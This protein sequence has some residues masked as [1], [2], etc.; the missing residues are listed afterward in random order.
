[1]NT[2][3]K[4]AF[5]EYSQF[6]E[7]GIIEKIFE[8][9]GTESKL[10]V[11]FGAWDGFHLSNTANL[12][13]NGW[14]G[15]LI[16]GNKKRFNSL[17]KKVENYNCICINA[18]VERNGKNSLEPLL[19]N[20]GISEQ[21]DLLSIDIDG[22]DYYIYESLKEIRPRVVICEYNPTIPAHI[23]LLA[24]YNNYFGCSV[25]SLNN[26]AIKKGYALV[27]ITQ[28]NCIFVL[29]E[30]EEL[31]QEFETRLKY[32]K[33]DNYVRYL[34][35]SYSGDYV[36]SKGELAY[37]VSFPYTGKLIGDFSVVN[38]SCRILRPLLSLISLLKKYFREKIK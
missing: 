6:G 9:I 22:N 5:N 37:G 8:I 33:N 27:A 35:T 31:F 25:A 11:E 34:I 7:D 16:E 30:L 32:I 36:L 26:L 18:F 3:T 20:H 13:T 12:W 4:F 15:V 10:C 19:N 38:F 28:T 29:K 17:C 21:L 24:E 2:L 23:E 14:K 1:M